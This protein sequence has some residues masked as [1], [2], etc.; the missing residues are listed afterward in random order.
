MKEISPEQKDRILRQYLGRFYGKVEPS[1]SALFSSE[2]S[3]AC[4]VWAKGRPQFLRQIG[5]CYLLKFGKLQYRF[6][7]TYEIVDTFLGKTPDGSE[8]SETFY[9]TVSSYL[10]LYHMGSTMENK[11][12]QNMVC[13]TIAQRKL[14]GKPTLVL[15]EVSLPQVEGTIR[16][17]NG[18]SII[19]DS[20]RSVVRG[21][22]I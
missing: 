11:Q 7:L 12:L 9:D 20:A 22:D 13:H 18:I 2:V 17:H 15:S 21:N 8:G 3:S 4:V 1:V 5:A 16:D 10:I 14:E 19:S 6:R